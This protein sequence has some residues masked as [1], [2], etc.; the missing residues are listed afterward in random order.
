MEK[1]AQKIQQNYMEMQM[2][3][4]Q[5]KQIQQQ[6]QMIEAQLIEVETTKQALKDLEKT[7]TGAETLAPISSG[8]FLKTTLVDNKKLKVNV[9]SGVVVEKTIL[10]VIKIIKEQEE[11]IR[12]THSNLAVEMQKLSTK[13]LEIEKA[14]K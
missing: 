14:L 4:Q 2:I 11:E 9:G 3:N 5:M 13:A 1:D 12:N 8:I 10:E 6:I 7:E